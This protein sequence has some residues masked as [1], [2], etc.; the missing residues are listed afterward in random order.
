MDRTLVMMAQWPQRRVRR[1]NGQDAVV[2]MD[3]NAQ[4]T[5][6][7]MNYQ[8]S[9]GKKYQRYFRLDFYDLFDTWEDSIRELP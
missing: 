4:D 2:F 6:I 1:A 9:D 3:P 7:C 5:Y 8:G